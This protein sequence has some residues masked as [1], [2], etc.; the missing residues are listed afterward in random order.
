MH[1]PPGAERAGKKGWPG[2]GDAVAR[3]LDEGAGLRKTVTS[4]DWRDG[5]RQCAGCAARVIGAAPDD[6]PTVRASCGS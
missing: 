5:D 2:D 3:F 4:S 1:T 6:V